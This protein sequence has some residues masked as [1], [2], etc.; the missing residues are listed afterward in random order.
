MICEFFKVKANSSR[1]KN[2]ER[3]VR[4]FSKCHSSD[5]LLSDRAL[6]NEQVG[7]KRLRCY[8]QKFKGIANVR[9]S[10][11][12][13]IQK[14]ITSTVGGNSQEMFTLNVATNIFTGVEQEVEAFSTYN[15]NFLFNIE[16]KA[17]S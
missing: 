8:M 5:M 6:G 14:G 4:I 7:K 2:Q 3:A 10:S 11:F 17:S 9:I 12:W 13:R 16:G 15:L 1:L